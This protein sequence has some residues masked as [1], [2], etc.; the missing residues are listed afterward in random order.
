MRDERTVACA[1]AA[2]PEAD[3]AASQRLSTLVHLLREGAGPRLCAVVLS[4]SLSRGEGVVIE[5]AGGLALLSDVDLYAVVDPVD[6]AADADLARH[7]RERFAGDSFL[8]APLDLGLVD[9][10]YFR[11]LGSTLP[12]RQLGHGHRVLWEADH[13]WARPSAALGEGAVDADD[14]TKLLHNRC[15]EQLLL[16][17]QSGLFGRFHRW[18]VWRDAPLAFL[19]AYGHYEPEREAQIQTLARLTRPWQGAAAHWAQSGLER[20]RTMQRALAAPLTPATLTELAGRDDELAG[21]VWPL[22]RAVLRRGLGAPDAA[23]TLEATVGEGPA[24]PQDARLHTRWLRRRGPWATIREARRWAPLTDA[25]VTPWWRHG[26]GGT[27]PDRVHLAAAGRFVGDRAWRAPLRG[28]IEPPP[29]GE[30]DL[31][32]WLG[33]LWSSWIMGGARP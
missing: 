17:A 4:G 7:L 30:A 8:L 9:A 23:A 32:A 20:L 15:A 11:R 31:D 6:P 21:W 27:G 5:T 24:G 16:R 12:A 2:S 25:P 10:G 13:A 18:K 29:I 22:H 33:G 26:L 3:A 19:A 14:A 1:V 28:L